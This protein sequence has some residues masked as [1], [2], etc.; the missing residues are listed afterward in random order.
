M[1]SYC[2]TCDKTMKETTGY[3]VDGQHF[4]YCAQCVQ[5]NGYYEK[6]GK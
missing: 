3:L 5:D 1:S 2:D 4:N 6:E